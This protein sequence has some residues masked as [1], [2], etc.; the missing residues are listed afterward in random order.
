MSRMCSV[1]STTQPC[2]AFAPPDRPV[3]APRVTTGTPSR[4]HAVTT[5]ATSAVLRGRTTATGLPWSAHSA[6]SC[7]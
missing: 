1:H 2:T 4:A 5:A 7:R 3:P 6:S